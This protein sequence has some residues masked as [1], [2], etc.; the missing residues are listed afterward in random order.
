[1][2][3][4]EFIALTTAAAIAPAMLSAKVVDYTPGMAKKALAEGKTVFLDF[5]ATWCS[6]CA[7]QDR[8]IT[9]LRGEN[10]DYDAN[11]TFIKVDWD[12]YGNGDLSNGLKIPRRST[13][14]VLKG[15]KEL[16]RIVAG[17]A[18][19]QIKKLMDTALKA[20]TA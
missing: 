19:K 1:M 20:A 11:I 7:A 17:T 3:R 13:L 14:V 5:S 4:R 18:R 15:D 10:P 8:V 16:G 6:T 2:K 9:A 12:D